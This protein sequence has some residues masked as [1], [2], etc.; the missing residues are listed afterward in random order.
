ML[1]N[2]RYNKYSTCTVSK[3]LFNSQEEFMTYRFISVSGVWALRYISY[4]NFRSGARGK[5]MRRSGVSAQMGFFKFRQNIFSSRLRLINRDQS[6][7]C[8]RDTFP[9]CPQS[10]WALVDTFTNM[11]DDSGNTV[12]CSPPPQGGNA[13]LTVSAGS[14]WDWSLKN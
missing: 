3:C 6:L 11:P 12:Q 2:R 4:H 10:Y 8:V 13:Q 1:Q 9:A 14:N 7:Q 5:T